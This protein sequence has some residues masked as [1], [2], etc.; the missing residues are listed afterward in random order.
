[1]AQ[2]KSETDDLVVC[3]LDEGSDTLIMTCHTHVC[4]FCCVVLYVISKDCQKATFSEGP[5]TVKQLHH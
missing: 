3:H 4:T 1:M 5:L 2:G